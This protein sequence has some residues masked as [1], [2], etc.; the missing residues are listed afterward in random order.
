MENTE[1]TPYRG[2]VLRRRPNFELTKKVSAIEYLTEAEYLQLCNVAVHPEHKLLL[3]LLWETGLRIS[4]AL[5][6][7]YGDVYP[8]GLNIRHGKGNKQR[9]VH[10]QAPI[11]GELLRY[12]R[13]H[14]N[15]MIFQKVRTRQAAWSLIKRL[16]VL[17]GI[18][19]RLHP[20]IFRH[21]YAI[22]FIKQ[23]GNP[24]ALQSQGGWSDMDIIKTYMRLASEMPAEAVNKMYFPEVKI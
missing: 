24:F 21:S 15:D 6:L 19:K 8:D 18:T 16:Q 12:A 13:S 17:A 10:C 3:R 5:S 14:A 22:N 9:M 23:T 11:L 7:K 2:H 1:L 20:H 4:E